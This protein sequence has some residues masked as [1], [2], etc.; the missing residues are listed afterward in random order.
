MTNLKNM[1]M[2]GA[3]VGVL[4]GLSACGTAEVRTE[5]EAGTEAIVSVES[6]VCTT[7][8]PTRYTD[9]EGGWGYTCSEAIR[10]A[11]T[12]LNQSMQWQC[13]AGTC[14]VAK[15]TGPCTPVSSNRLD[16]FTINVTAT[17]SCCG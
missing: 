1:L 11:N 7:C 10:D 2:R 8:L 9:T 14:N 3:V 6:A 16:G 15:T 12:W 17:Y 4:L 13:P 5:P